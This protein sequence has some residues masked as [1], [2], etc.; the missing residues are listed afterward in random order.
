M[1]LPVDL[2]SLVVTD[3]P[4]F[5]LE[6]RVIK[7][8]KWSLHIG[9]NYREGVVLSD[10]RYDG[11]PTFYRLSISDM[12]VPYGDPRVSLF[13]VCCTH[14]HSAQSPYHRKQ[15]FDLGD[16]GAGLTANEL[17]LGCDCLGE[18]LVSAATCDQTVLY[19]YD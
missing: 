7:W 10:V 18:I 16:V 14:T 1:F 6:G 2:D 8:Q 11:R 5:Q 3:D 13:P 12:T 19:C 15:A 9:F 17:A 4:Q